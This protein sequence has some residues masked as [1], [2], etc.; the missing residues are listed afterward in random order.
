MTLPLTGLLVVGLEQAIAAPFCTRQLADLG[1]RVIKVESE[2][3]DFTRYYDDVVHGTSAH[4]AWANRG[5]QSLV[6]DLKSDVGRADLELLLDRA[7]VLVQNLAPGTAE[8]L[9]FDARAATSRHPRLIAVDI[10]GYGRGGPK[11]TARAYDLLVQSESGSCAITG[12]PDHP[13]KPGVPLVDLG[14][15]MHAANAIM[16]AL[17]E[18]QSTGRGRAISVGMF[19]VATEWMSFAFHQARY[20]GRNLEPNG[21][22]SPLVAPYGAY[23]TADGQT[24]VVGTTSDR[25][26]QRLARDVLGRPDLAVDPRYASNTDRV[27]RRQELEGAIAEWAAQRDF[28]DIAKTVDAAQLGWARFNRPTDVLEHPQLTERGRWHETGSP[29]GSFPTLAPPADVDG[30][31]WQPHPVPAVGEHTASI[32]AEF[33]LSAASS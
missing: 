21:L 14:T 25:E 13:A 23:Q 2:A 12:T 30:W 27:A 16:A 7:D 10:S 24:I 8:R 6:L 33:G 26:W 28:D 31:D 11:A 9:G 4:F 19:D 18:R 15:G 1:A 17:L 5:K 32:A 29:G 3:G 22:S 20:T